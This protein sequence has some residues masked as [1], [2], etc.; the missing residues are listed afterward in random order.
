MQKNNLLGFV[1]LVCVLLGGA[2][3]FG[4]ESGAFGERRYVGSPKPNRTADH[5]PILTPN[6]NNDNNNSRPPCCFYYRKPFPDGA[7]VAFAGREPIEFNILGRVETAP[8][9]STKQISIAVLAIIDKLEVIK[10]KEKI[11]M[12]ITERILKDA[13]PQKNDYLLLIPVAKYNKFAPEGM[14]DFVKIPRE[15]VK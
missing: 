2:E 12:S 3:L 6:D 1:V 13:A 14:Y 7:M 9:Y 4:R 8:D 10:L 15:L 5:S 11:V